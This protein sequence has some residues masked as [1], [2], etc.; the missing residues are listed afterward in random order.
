MKLNNSLKL[1]SRVRTSTLVTGRIFVESLVAGT[2]SKD[3]KKVY[4]SGL[5]SR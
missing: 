5:E 4:N 1:Q 3:K 2:L